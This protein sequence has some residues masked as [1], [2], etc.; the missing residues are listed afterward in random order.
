MNKLEKSLKIYLTNLTYDTI[1]IATD[2][3]PYN[4]GCIASYSKKKFG[5]KLDLQVLL[6]YC[7]LK[8]VLPCIGFYLDQKIP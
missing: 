5:N 2:A 8:N 6:E 7:R 3:F 1:A 4:V